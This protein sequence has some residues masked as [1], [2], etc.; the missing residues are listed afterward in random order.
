MGLGLLLVTPTSSISQS[1]FSTG[2]G[3]AQAPINTST[4]IQPLGQGLSSIR[5]LRW[6]GIWIRSG[7]MWAWRPTVRYDWQAMFRCRS[8][9]GSGVGWGFNSP[10]GWSGGWLPDP[11]SSWNMVSGLGWAWFPSQRYVNAWNFWFLGPRHSYGY[12]GGC[13]PF[14]AVFGSSYPF[15]GWGGGLTMANTEGPAQSFR[16]ERWDRS[17]WE[18]RNREPWTPTYESPDRPVA[19]IDPVLLLPPIT[20]DTKDQPLIDPVRDLPVVTADPRSRPSID[21]VLPVGGIET[22][23]RTNVKSTQQK[24]VRQDRREPKVHVQEG[25]PSA[26]SRASGAPK[27]PAATPSRSS[28]SR[29]PA[30][31]ETKRSPTPKATGRSTATSR[32]STPRKATGTAKSSKPA[33]KGKKN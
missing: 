18:A 26:R 13:D 8:G 16:P 23:T 9:Y 22:V 10:W 14:G 29:A 27:R 28:P 5:E 19:F 12:G 6:N 33:P 2:A 15:T 21:P 4:V 30:R 31:V 11:Y 17:E 3:I 32:P 25:K 1:P 7:G 20:R 24:D